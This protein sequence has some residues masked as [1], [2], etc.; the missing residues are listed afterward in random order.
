VR[1]ATMSDLLADSAAERR[2]AFL[3]FQAFALAALALAGAGIFGVI[4][5][6]VAERA[7][8]IGVRAVLGAS[9][10]NIMALV[11]GQG[12]ALTVLGIGIGAL[13]AGFAGQ[14][15]ITLLFQVSPLDPATY[16]VVTALVILVAL[17]ACALPAW[18][19]LRIDPAITLRVD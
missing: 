17:I 10:W 19:A 9:R 14:A 12:M 11:L 6:S 1:V 7:R 15:L 16:F 2:F 18:R 5:G 13:A 8:E 3:I 4:S